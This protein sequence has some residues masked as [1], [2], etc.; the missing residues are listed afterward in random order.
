MYADKEGSQTNTDFVSGFIAIWI[1]VFIVVSLFVLVFGNVEAKKERRIK[2]ITTYLV[3]NDCWAINY[4]RTQTKE[5]IR[6]SVS[7]RKV[8]YYC[9]NQPK[10]PVYSEVYV[11]SRNAFRADSGFTKEQK[12]KLHAEMTEN[13]TKYEYIL[14][15]PLKLDEL[16]KPKSKKIESGAPIN[17]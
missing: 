4:V 15:A 13:G 17:L 8:A 9:K 6:V 11:G 7:E 16:A 1:I 14:P 2:K 10:N 3:Q 5:P 12:I